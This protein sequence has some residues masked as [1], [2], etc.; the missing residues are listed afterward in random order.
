MGRLKEK[1]F[2]IIEKIADLKDIEFG[3]LAYENLQTKFFDDPFDFAKKYFSDLDSDDRRFLGYYEEVEG[4]PEGTEALEDILDNWPKCPLG[5]TFW[6]Q[7][8]LKETKQRRKALLFGC[9]NYD[10]PDF[11][12]LACPR[13]DVAAFKSM[14]KSRKLGHFN[15][16]EVLP[17]K[18]KASGAKKA[19]CNLIQEAEAGDTL[20]IYFSGHGYASERGDKIFLAVK[21][22][23]PKIEDSA[24]GGN[25]IIE[26]Y[27]ESKCTSL[28][29]ILDCC[30]SGAITSQ[31]GRYF[32]ARPRIPKT[33]YTNVF[34]HGGFRVLTSSTRGQHSF[35]DPNSGLSIFSS[36]F[37][38]G[39][40]SGKADTDGDGVITDNELFFYLRRKL[41][42]LNLFD[43]QMPSHSIVDGRSPFLLALNNY[44]VEPPSLFETPIQF[45]DKFIAIRSMVDL[46]NSYEP[47]I[48]FVSCLGYKFNGVNAG[49]LASGL[50]VSAEHTPFLCQTQEGFQCDT[51]FAEPLVPKKAQHNHP[52]NGLVQ[53]RLDVRLEDILMIIGTD[54]RS[55]KR[56]NL[57]VPEDTRVTL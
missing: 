21:D 9:G 49:A 2:E 20:L 40:N 32:R 18:E 22:T 43:Q 19:I 52:I 11:S 39:I 23:D 29:L 38:E 47:I 27:A 36:F 25:D 55:R 44:C 33:I 53:T 42:A 15:S 17:A 10:H 54:L 13:K 7:N 1:A 45:V 51:F 41:G 34:G 3:S 35:E 26:A 24:V 16:V 57:L 28:L 31:L 50:S 6:T 30:Q 4:K 56:W 37:L 48:F 46:V 14:L 12:R 8:L 5:G